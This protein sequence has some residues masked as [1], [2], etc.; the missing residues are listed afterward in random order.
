[1]GEQ[2]SVAPNAALEASAS[3]S[4]AAR[5]L[6]NA[7]SHA[8]V[9]GFAILDNQLRYQAINSALVATNGFPAAAHLG[10]TIRDLFG[11]RVADEIQPHI[12]TLSATGNPSVAEIVATLPTRNEPGWWIDY[13]FPIKAPRGKMIGLGVV[14]VEVTEQ[15]KLERAIDKLARYLLQGQD[16]EGLKVA[17]ELRDSVDQYHFA[18]SM[19]MSQVAGTA[20]KSPDAL[21]E[22]V[23]ALD[24]RIG[25]MR[26]LIA[27]VASKFPVQTNR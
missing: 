8:S 26:Q 7:F 17:R 22:A 13:Y 4:D 16:R 20:D 25:G 6:S 24:E 19:S 14:V 3:V 9:L 21:A 12:N 1:M 18:L 15:R 27:H 5:S 23:D 11:N 2:G 10:N